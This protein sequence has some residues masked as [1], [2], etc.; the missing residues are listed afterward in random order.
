[1]GLQ[2]SN[3]NAVYQAQELLKTE[4]DIFQTMINKYK[5]DINTYTSGIEELDS[6]IKNFDNKMHDIYHVVEL[7]TVNAVQMM[8]LMSSLREISRKRRQAI[9][10]KTA[11]RDLLKTI[12][13]IYEFLASRE[14]HTHLFRHLTYSEER[15][16]RY[17]DEAVDCYHQLTGRHI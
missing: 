2:L 4:A 15:I 7:K 5:Q 14:P 1:M 11:Y 12:K 13:P 10:L 9:E 6:I 16:Q 3:S 8:Q 17:K